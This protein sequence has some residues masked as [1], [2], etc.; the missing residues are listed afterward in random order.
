MGTEMGR[1]T[2][3]QMGRRRSGRAG[4]R[5]AGASAGRWSGNLGENQERGAALNDG[6]ATLRPCLLHTKNQKLFNTM[7]LTAHA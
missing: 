7:N 4:S 1:L 5:E 3:W 6:A 2:K